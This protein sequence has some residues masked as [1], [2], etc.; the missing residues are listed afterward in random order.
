M[1]S[2]SF[3]QPTK[4]RS[5][6]SSIA[7]HSQGLDTDQQRE[8]KTISMQPPP[9]RPPGHCW[10]ALALVVQRPS[11][12]AAAHMCCMVHARPTHYPWHLKGL[13]QALSHP[14]P[15]LDCAPSPVAL[16]HSSPSNVL[17]FA[18][19]ISRM[20]PAL[21]GTLPRTTI[22]RRSMSTLSTCRLRTLRRTLPIWPAIFRPGKL[23]P[24]V[25]PGP[26]LPCSR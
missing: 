13:S 24:G 2:S 22:A 26:V 9:A 17:T 20:F 1:P 18:G 23:R 10:N 19:A 5:N 6:S 21:P 7:T 16:G 8:G 15:T 14:A 3:R 12:T 25:V 11:G 4:H